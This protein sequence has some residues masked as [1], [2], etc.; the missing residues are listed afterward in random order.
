MKVARVVSTTNCDRSDYDNN[1]LSDH[2]IS[3]T[4]WKFL[5]T[6]YQRA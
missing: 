3:I 5:M 4:T 2:P 6:A 1:T